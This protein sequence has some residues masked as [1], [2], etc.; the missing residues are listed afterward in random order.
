MN[1]ARVL[2]LLAALTGSGFLQAQTLPLEEAIKKSLSQNLNIQLT[3]QSIAIA[4]EQNSIGNAGMLP[5]IDLNAGGS[6]SNSN[7]ELTILGLPEPLNV[8][9]AQATALNTSLNSE[10]CFIQWICRTEHLQ[11]VWNCARPSEY[12]KTNGR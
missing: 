5:T 6:Y 2:F 8:T 10:L 1:T 9:G 3:D 7:A 12:P 11:E 4:E